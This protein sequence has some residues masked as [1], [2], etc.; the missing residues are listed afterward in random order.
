[1]VALL[2]SR[3]GRFV[4]A[5]QDLVDV[6]VHPCGFTCFLSRSM[7]GSYDSHKSF[8]NKLKFP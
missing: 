6:S 2:R 3:G 1:M 4:L 8:L 5:Y 7:K